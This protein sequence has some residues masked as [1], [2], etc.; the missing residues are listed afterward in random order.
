[1]IKNT[2]IIILTLLLIVTLYSYYCLANKMISFQDDRME[3]IVGKEKELKEKDII[4]KS[5]SQFQLEL[6]NCKNSINIAKNNIAD[7]IIEINKNNLSSN[8]N[9]VNSE[10]IVNAENI[11]NSENRVYNS[12]PYKERY[13]NNNDLFILF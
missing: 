9:I 12:N 10:N 2:I 1:M 3:Y 8:Q 4:L 11:V 13:G 5:C 7:N 6:N